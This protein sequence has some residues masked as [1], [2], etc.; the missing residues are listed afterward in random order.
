M[1]TAIT[2]SELNIFLFA[3]PNSF[4]CIL[5][6]DSC[7]YRVSMAVQIKEGMKT[8]ATIMHGNAVSFMPV[9]VNI[10]FLLLRKYIYLIIE[11]CLNLTS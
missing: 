1:L 2:S 6:L 5:K 10:R 4:L 8:V 9:K 3:F 11:L 7:E